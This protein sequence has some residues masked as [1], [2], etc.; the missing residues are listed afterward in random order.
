MALSLIT[1]FT[2]NN[3]ENNKWKQTKPI[4]AATTTKKENAYQNLSYFLS[5]MPYFNLWV[6]NLQKTHCVDKNG[7]LRYEAVSKLSTLFAA[8]DF[9]RVFTARYFLWLKNYCCYKLTT[10]TF[11]AS[12]CWYSDNFEESNKYSL[13][14]DR[15]NVIWQVS[16]CLLAHHSILI[17]PPY[18]W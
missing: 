2:S 3:N 13:A 14:K 5:L 11:S 18:D 15:L 9:K 1:F 4:A 12:L 10:F 6:C 7:K 16:F 17:R 8:M